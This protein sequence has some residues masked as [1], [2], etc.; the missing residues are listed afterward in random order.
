MKKFI[1]AAIITIAAGSGLFAQNRGNNPS[2]GTNKT[3][4]GYVDAN[5]NNV[6]DNYE[7]N[8][9]Q[10]LGRGKAQGKGSGY[11]MATRQGRMPLQGRGAGNGRRSL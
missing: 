9:R 11:C 7:N 8:T 5:K 4:P 3:C 10:F 6:C 1:L 2:P